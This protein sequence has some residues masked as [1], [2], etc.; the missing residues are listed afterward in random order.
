MWRIF[1]A[2]W[3]FPRLWKM[4]TGGGKELPLTT[5]QFATARST[6]SLTALLLATED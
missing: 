1:F 4:K 3:N 6:D 5:V 2:V